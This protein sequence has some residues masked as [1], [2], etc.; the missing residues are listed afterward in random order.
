MIFYASYAFGLIFITCE[1][2]Q[3]LSDAFEEIN[4]QIGKFNWYWFPNNLKA[5]LPH[6]IMVS[7]QPV[8]LGCFGSITCSRNSFKKVSFFKEIIKI[9]WEFDLHYCNFTFQ[10]VNSAF[11]YFTV[12][13]KFNDWN[14]TFFL[15]NNNLFSKKIVYQ[16]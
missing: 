4:N 3:R 13:R 14:F 10:V 11:S 5:I 9:W 2:G 1:L 8:D 6:I 15:L 7:Q 12:L 16:N